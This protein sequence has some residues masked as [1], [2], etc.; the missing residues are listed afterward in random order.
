MLRIGE[1]HERP[2]APVVPALEAAIRVQEM[3][4]SR[5]VVPLIL[6]R[7]QLV[8]TGDDAYHAQPPRSVLR[9]QLAAVTS[10]L[11]TAPS[12]GCSELQ[13]YGDAGVVL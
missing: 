4:E 6:Q 7:R 5:P 8:V 2:S 1:H 9:R 12:P 10:I 11:L 13:I 3:N